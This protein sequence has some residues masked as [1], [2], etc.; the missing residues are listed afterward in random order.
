MAKDESQFIAI[1]EKEFER[2]KKDKPKVGRTDTEMAKYIGI[3]A[4]T[5]SHYRSGRRPMSKA[6]ADEI[7]KTLRP[8]RDFDNNQRAELAKA[9]ITACAMGMKNEVSAEDWLESIGK[10]GPLLVV[11][12]RD[13]PSARS[14]N[15]DK[16]VSRT[17]A[18]M[19][20]RS[21]ANGLVYALL[22]PF[23][24]SYE[25][26][27]NIENALKSYAGYLTAAITDTYTNILGEAYKQICA[28]HRDDESARDASFEEVR[29]R[30]RVYRLKD[31]GTL[32]GTPLDRCPGLGYKLFY[33]RENIEKPADIW[34]WLSTP[35]G[36]ALARNNKGEVE[37]MAIECRFYPLLECAEALLERGEYILPTNQDMEIHAA[38][39]GIKPLWE[40]VQ[41]VIAP[42]LN[43]MLIK[44]AISS[45]EMR[46]KI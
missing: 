29:R 9:L 40:E 15:P 38:A 7:A 11:E 16:G 3:P 2:I 20:G 8:A 31:D 41:Q 22:N 17:M 26:N 12:F 45:E 23:P 27:P 6:A 44:N 28:K 13:F 18:K 19:A 4:S 43:E 34:Y 33:L 25:N 39:K 10:F 5:F 14:S 24:P 30:L 32:S 46:P 21:V 37:L 42:Q 35:D 1:L 36:E